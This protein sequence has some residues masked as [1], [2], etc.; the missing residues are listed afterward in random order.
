MGNLQR[1]VKITLT[2]DENEYAVIQHAVADLSVV[3]AKYESS[4]YKERVMN[5]DKLI[6]PNPVQEHLN[7]ER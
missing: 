3:V 7:S 4:R 1:E 2:L 6:N 5:L